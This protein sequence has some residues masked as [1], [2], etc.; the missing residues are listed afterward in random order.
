MMI[1]T[2]KTWMQQ[3]GWSQAILIADERVATVRISG[4]HWTKQ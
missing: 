1:D 4:L 3:Y 2:L